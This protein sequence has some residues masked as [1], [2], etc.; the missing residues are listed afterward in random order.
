[1]HAYNRHFLFT[2]ALRKES[3]NRIELGVV[4]WRKLQIFEKDME[5]D[6]VSRHREPLRFP[7]SS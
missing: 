4:V 1:M 2:L 3:P 5:V 6:F 7:S